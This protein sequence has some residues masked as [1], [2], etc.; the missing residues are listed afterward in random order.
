M[1]TQFQQ[2]IKRLEAISL[3]N[4]PT[5]PWNEE[6]RVDVAFEW[7]GKEDELKKRIE[8]LELK[9]KKGN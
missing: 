5:R 3:I 4:H 9:I 7:M 1:E 2:L 8:S 6:F